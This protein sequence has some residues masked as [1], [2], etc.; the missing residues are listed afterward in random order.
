MQYIYTYSVLSHLGILLCWRVFE[1]LYA[2]LQIMAHLSHSGWQC[3]QLS[4]FLLASFVNRVQRTSMKNRDPVNILVV[5][6]D[7]VLN[8]CNLVEFKKNRMWLIIGLTSDR[9]EDCPTGAP[10]TE[11]GTC[12]SDISWFCVRCAY[13]IKLLNKQK[14]GTRTRTT[15][16]QSSKPVPCHRSFFV[17]GCTQQPWECL[18]QRLEVAGTQ[19]RYKNNSDGDLTGANILSSYVM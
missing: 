17:V 2:F 4:S 1:P 11:G 15:N 18:V 7:V 10:L 9:N 3:V 6:L 5:F 19:G 16:F 13:I 8:R 14:H 12:R